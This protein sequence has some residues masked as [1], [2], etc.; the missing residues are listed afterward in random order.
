MLDLREIEIT[1]NDLNPTF[2]DAFEQYLSDLVTALVLMLLY[3]QQ[4]LKFVHQN[5]ILL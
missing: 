4:H 1:A 2:G 3:K 5:K